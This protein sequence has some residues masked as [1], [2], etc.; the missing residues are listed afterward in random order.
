MFVICAAAMPMVFKAPKTTLKAESVSQGTKP[1]AKPRHKKHSTSLKQPFVSSSETAK[2]GSSKRPTGSKTGYLKRKKESSSAM[3]SNPSQTSASTQVVA[4]MHKED[5]QATGDSNSLGVTI[6]ER[7]NPQL[8]SGMPTFN[9]N[10]PI[11]SSSFIIHSESASGY[12]ASADSTAKADPGLSAPNDFIPHQQGVDEG[13]KNTSFDHIS[14]GTDPH[15]LADQTKSVS[16]ELET[17]LTQPILGKG[18]SSIA[19]QVVEEEASK[20][21]KLEDLEKLVSHVQPRFKDLDSPKDDPIIVVDD[22]DED[23]EE[24][25]DEKLELEKN[26]AEAD[27]LRAQPSFPNMGQFN[28]LMAIASKKTKDDS[29]P[30]TGQAGT[31]PAKGEKNANQATI[32]QLFKKSCKECKPDQT[33]IKTNTTTYNTNHS[34]SHHNHRNSNAISFSLKS[35]K[36]SSQP[37]GGYIRKDKGKKALSSE[38]VG[39][40]S[41]DN[42][43]DD[44]ETHVTG[45]MV[46]SSRIMKEKDKAKRKSEVRKEELVDLLGPE[47]PITLKV[48]NFKASDLHIGEWGEVMNACPNRTRKGWTTIYDQIRSRM[49]Y[50]HTTEAELGINLDIPLSKQDPLDKL[51]DLANKKRKHVD[52]IHDYFKANK[53]LKQDF[54][55]IEDMKDFSNTMLYSVQ[56]IFFRRH[57]GPR[58]DDH[59][60]TFSSLLLAEVDKRNLNPLKQMG[61]IE[62]LRQ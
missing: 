23:E 61:T 29:V 19:R 12:D 35:T 28:E 43:Y 4:E 44:D 17:V 13:T 40:E 36:N 30:S 41:T 1:R 31:Q 50:I 42:D 14:A 37:E 10:E 26:T 48:P 20:T 32:S 51:N 2:G 62:Q 58:L 22:S 47:S 11:F 57:Q 7:A 54:V 21:I 46:E 27:L 8:S 6:D 16:K 33:K 59:A 18:S 24:D 9:L 5:L 39:K 34:S 38:K 45:S 52:D 53:R 15:V 60:R 3:D 56:E 49:D 55:T 25:K